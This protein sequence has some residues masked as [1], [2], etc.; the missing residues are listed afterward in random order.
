MRTS[1]ILLLSIFGVI[2]NIRVTNLRCQKLFRDDSQLF[3][4]YPEKPSLKLENIS[5]MVDNTQNLQGT[6]YTSICDTVKIPEGCKEARNDAKLVFITSNPIKCL[7]VSNDYNWEYEINKHENSEQKISITQLGNPSYKVNYDFVCEPQASIPDFKPTYDAGKMLFNITVYSDAG[8]GIHLTFFD[9][10]AKNY[11]VTAISFTIIGVILCFFGLKFYKDFLMFFIPLLIL[12]LG[13]YFYMSLIET[14]ASQNERIM[15][16]FFLIFGNMVIMTLAVLFSNVI[17]FVICLLTSYQLGLMAHAY[18][19][20]QIDFFAKQHT[21]WILITFFFCL[22]FSLYLKLQDYFIIVNTA[23]LGA[24]SLMIS[25][26]Y[27]G[28]TK[29]DFLFNIEM[30]KFD[31]IKQ[32]N[33]TFLNI[34]GLFALTSL[35]GMLIQYVL[36]KKDCEKKYRNDDIRIDLKLTP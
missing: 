13:F 5:L 1:F 24:F 7:I 19:L 11:L 18:L 25:L 34:L 16:I 28:L 35:L 30:D 4:Y 2:S 20:T 32:M 10:L 3:F 23:L 33:G 22:L 12:I 9:V 36:F 31:D 21:E 6:L 26:S 27:Y 8:C 14:S 29:F 17:Y 15:L